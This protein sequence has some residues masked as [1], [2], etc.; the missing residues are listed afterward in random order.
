[1]FNINLNRAKRGNVDAV[2]SYKSFLIITPFFIVI[3]IFLNFV[4]AYNVLIV[5]V[6]KKKKKKNLSLTTRVIII[7]V[8]FKMRF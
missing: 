7:I 5:I 4:N 6:K 3:F 2:F 8:C 1:M